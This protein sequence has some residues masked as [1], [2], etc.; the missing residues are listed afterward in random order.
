V[1]NSFL[2]ARGF[3]P[4]FRPFE[5]FGVAS[6]LDMLVEWAHKGTITSLDHYDAQSFTFTEYPAFQLPAT[7]VEV[8]DVAG[9]DQPLVRLRTTT[10]HSLWLMKA[11]EPETGIT[12]NALAQ[13]ALTSVRS[14]N[15]QWTVGVIVP[16]LEMD[17][18]PDL[19]WMLGAHTFSPKAGFQEVVQAFQMFKLRANEKGARVKVATGFATRATMSLPPE[20][21]PF[22]EPFIGF[23]TQPGHETLALAPFWADTDVWKAPE[24]TLEE[25]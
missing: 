10:G 25:L 3:D 13:K 6:I 21:Y 12:L 9:F 18:K 11:G 7:G 14:W 15:S 17:L 16:M 24:G 8:Y 2:K 22:D 23:F 4:M 20:P 19:N 1:L 5:G